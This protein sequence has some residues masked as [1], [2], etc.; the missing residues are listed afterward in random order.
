[1]FRKNKQ[2]QPKSINS[3]L[4]LSGPGQPTRSEASGVCSLARGEDT[5]PA[6]HEQA[7]KQAPCWGQPSGLLRRSQSENKANTEEEGGIW[8][9]NDKQSQS[10]DQTIP[11]ADYF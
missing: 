8:K 10:P 5:L 6:V 7:R 1:M 2:C 11:E 4:L 9:T 3:R